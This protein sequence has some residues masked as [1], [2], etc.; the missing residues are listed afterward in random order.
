M[1]QIQIKQWN[2]GSNEERRDTVAVSRP[3]ALRVIITA[4]TGMSDNKQRRV[5]TAA[6]IQYFALYIRHA[7]H[8]LLAKLLRALNAVE[9]DTRLAAPGADGS[10]ARNRR[11]RSH[12]LQENGALRWLNP[13][14]PLRRPPARIIHQNLDTLFA[15]AGH[16][17]HYPA[18]CQLRY[19]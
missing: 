18:G 16:S 11:R 12:V 10:V 17:S 9:Q 19:G 4:V 1:P 8:H 15:A 6:R 7:G 13:I 5:C 2:R 14:A 3:P